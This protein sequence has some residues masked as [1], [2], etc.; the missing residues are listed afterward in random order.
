MYKDKFKKFGGE[1]IPDI[2]EYLKSQIEKNPEIT[3]SV[4]CDSIQ[5]RKK[6]TYASTI[7]MYN[8]DIK[9][10]AHVVFYRESFPKMRDNNERLFKEAQICYDIAEYLNGELSKFYKRGDL[11]DFQRKAY[12]YHLMKCS[13]DYDYLQPSDL[14]RYISSLSLTP[15]EK[16]TEYKL[17]DI[18]LDYNPFESSLHPRGKTINRSNVAYKAYVPWLRS[19]NYRTYCKPLSYASTS[20][21]DLLLQD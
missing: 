10:G 15:G 13:K 4:G 5:K 3:I 9:N 21:A 11:S 19:M 12:K 1:W 8:N 20:A 2:I 6:T 17:V 18:H 14:D 7:M 16:E